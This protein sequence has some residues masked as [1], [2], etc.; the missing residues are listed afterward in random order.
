MIHFTDLMRNGIAERVL[1]GQWG[2]SLLGLVKLQT[3]T[4]AL[5]R[6]LLLGLRPSATRKEVQAPV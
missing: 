3:A 5:S 4:L 2:P 1:E 6:S